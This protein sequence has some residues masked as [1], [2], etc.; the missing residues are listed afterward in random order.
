MQNEFPEWVKK[1]QTT[2]YLAHGYAVMAHDQKCLILMFP[3]N[4]SLAFRQA[5]QP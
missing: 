4:G 1:V 5:P 3:W 2:D